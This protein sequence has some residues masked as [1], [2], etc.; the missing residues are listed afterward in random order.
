MNLPEVIKDIL[1]RYIFVA[2]AKQLLEV[3][4]LC[5]KYQYIH[6]SVL[7]NYRKEYFYKKLLS[8]KTFLANHKEEAL[9]RGIKRYREPG[10]SLV[11]G[12]RI[13]KF[14]HKCLKSIFRCCRCTNKYLDTEPLFQYKYKN[15]CMCEEEVFLK[16]LK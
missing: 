14:R 8:T 5:K 10:V 13:G 3:R 9:K 7:I 16:N 12:P 15:R 6:R 1:V 2:S 4:L 11:L